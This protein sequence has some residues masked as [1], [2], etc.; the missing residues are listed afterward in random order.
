[1]LQ[2][3]NHLL[4]FFTVAVLGSLLYFYFDPSYNNIFPPCPFYTVTGFYCPGCG[5]Q[6]A[7]HALL[8]G[9]IIQS[10]HKNILFVIFLP[11]MLFSLL[12]TINNI[13]RNKKTAQGIFN[14]VLF[15]KMVLVIVLSFW[16]L[17]NIP[18]EPFSWLAP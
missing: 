16:V 8:H 1:M 6:R 3:K 4:I 12:A 15:T 2:T 17:R 5:S 18:A 13:T 7:F 9:D 11:L 10:A 14:S